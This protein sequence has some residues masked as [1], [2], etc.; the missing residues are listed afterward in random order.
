M[1]PRLLMLLLA[2]ILLLSCT[3][4]RTS[5]AADDD[6]VA[7]DD[8]DVVDDDDDDLAPL[9]LLMTTDETTQ[10]IVLLDLETGAPTHAVDLTSTGNG[11]STVF[12][13]DGTLYRSAGTT[14]SVVDVCTGVV[15]TVDSFSGDR[16]I[17]GLATDD[18]FNLY[19]L[20]TWA[21]ELV[22]I[23][24]TTAVTTAIGPTGVSWGNSGLT[25]DPSRGAFLAIDAAT[26]RLYEIDPDTGAATWLV[27]I[28][29]DFDSLGLE[30]D[31]NSGLL[32]ACG[33]PELVRVDPWTGAVDVLGP[34][35]VAGCNDL[36]ATWFDVPCL[37]KL[38]EGAE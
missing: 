31:P 15:T 19:G 35:G 26:D 24:R 33:G 22:A 27:T 5:A 25:W 20:D 23:D 6:D 14:L 38:L 12:T 13:R 29:Y 17:P 2:S 1:N 28:D 8:D 30:V 36:A 32:Y 16:L 11:V 3:S 18:V 9:T 10:A 4:R 37:S 21:G 34:I 7:G